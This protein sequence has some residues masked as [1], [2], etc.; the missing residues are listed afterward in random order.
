MGLPTTANYIVVSSL[1]APVI[2]SLGAANDIAIPLIAAHMFVFYFGILADDTPPVGLA[3]FAAAAISKGDPIKTGIQGF[4]YDI[5][6]ALLPF[7]FIFNTQLLMIDI[8]NTFEFIMVIISAVVGMLLFAAATQGFWFTKNRWYETVLLLALT[9]MIFRPGYLW[10][11]VQAPYENLA[12]SEIFKVA[13]TMKKGDRLQFVVSGETLEGVERTYTFALPLAQG[14]DGKQRVNDT[15]FQ[16]DNMFG[17]MEVAM[18][19][20]GNNKQV[21]AMKNAG[22]DSGWIIESVRVKTDRLPK[23]IVLIPAFLIMFL[24]GWLQIK[25]RKA[26]QY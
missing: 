19:L 22:V 4:T 1:M 2:V 16:L 14:K 3:A 25:R 18:I 21:E 11:K 26:I 15:G 23:Q 7:M 12:G 13:D 5:R 9:F 20:P 6:T 17:P 10:D 8:G 24:L